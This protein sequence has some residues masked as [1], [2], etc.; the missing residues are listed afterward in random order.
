MATTT[1]AGTRRKIRGVVE[2][3][4]IIVVAL[5]LSI[6]V[7]DFA[8]QTFYIPSGSMEPTLQVGDRII[9]DKLSVQ[10]GSINRGDII[11]FKAPAA[12]ASACGDADQDLV[13]RVIGI[14]GDH[15]MSKGNTIYVNGK[16][17]HEGWSHYEPLGPA[18]KPT[19]VP[20][21]EYF[22]VG[23]NHSDS[24]D[25]RFWGLLPRGNMIGKVFVR[26]WPLSRISW[27]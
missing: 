4:A 15:L 14:P 26:V 18:I 2:W 16:P 1:T 11:V 8:F 24:C 27:I 6:L 7:R 12:V 5:T 3:L 22:M 20:A 19:V 23:D 10:F 21:N 9:V 17:L 13:K 25:S